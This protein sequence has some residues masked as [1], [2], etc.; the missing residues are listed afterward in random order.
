MAGRGDLSRGG[1]GREAE[2]GGAG[3]MRTFARGSALTSYPTES[4]GVGVFGT[5]SRKGHPA[6]PTRHIEPT[7]CKTPYGHTPCIAKFRRAVYVQRMSFDA[8]ASHSSG[9]GCHVLGLC[10]ATLGCSSR[11]A[12]D[13]GA[14]VD[15]AWVAADVIPSDD[16]ARDAAVATG[17]VELPTPAADVPQL[18]C[19]SEPVFTRC[20]YSGYATACHLSC[21]YPT[22]CEF[23]IAVQ[24]SGGNYC[25][26][27]H[28]PGGLENFYGCRCLDGQVICLQGD[29]GVR[30]TSYCE[31]CDAQSGGPRDSGVSPDR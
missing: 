22:T 30:P 19:P 1:R 9:K 25:C 31:F 11:E 26:L 12:R 5:S 4:A 23:R 18:P 8:G 29:A 28:G 17:D 15:V 7:P 14:M 27:I 24:W 10:L 2:G 20:G 3:V 6:A 16:R 21:A 13:A